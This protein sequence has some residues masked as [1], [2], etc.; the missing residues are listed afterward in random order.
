M[1]DDMQRRAVAS[2]E[3]AGLVAAY[4]RAVRGADR[5]HAGLI[6]AGLDPDE[7]TVVAG[8]GGDGESVVHVTALPVVA[9]QLA[10]LIADDAVPPPSFP[11]WYPCRGDPDVA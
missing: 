7:L 11:T 2:G 5:L 3:V 1:D 9:V 10:E 4:R 8:L 6:V